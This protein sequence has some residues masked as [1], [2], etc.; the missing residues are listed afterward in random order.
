MKATS[1][2]DTLGSTE[3]HLAGKAALAEAID[4]EQS[5][6]SG[7]RLADLIIPANDMIGTRLLKQLG[8]R[9]GFGIGPRK[10]RRNSDD[11]HG[12][13]VLYA[14]EDTPLPSYV[15]KTNTHGI[16]YNP[17]QNAPEFAA[18]A[19]TTTKQL[20]KGTASKPAGFGVGVFEDEED[21]VY[22]VDDTEKYDRVL[23]E[24]HP[25]VGPK[26]GM[27]KP[28][29]VSNGSVGAGNLSNFVRAELAPTVN[30]RNYPL[31]S[32]PIDYVEKHVF[33]AD[34]L[35]A[36]IPRRGLT[37]DDRGKLLGETPVKAPKRS[38]F[39]LMR[40]EAAAEL[41]AY[42]EKRQAQ[43]TAH[44]SDAPIAPAT[45]P[46]GPLPQVVHVEPKVAMSAL[47]GF[48]PFVSDQAKQARYVAFCERNAGVPTATPIYPAVSHLDTLDFLVGPKPSVEHVL[49]GKTH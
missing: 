49:V 3:R 32:V 12:K 22:G 47:K 29:D 10:R 34:D 42:F 40:P 31:P 21:D 26:R 1:E 44:V 43:R 27:R 15:M 4:Q 33:E 39:D 5:L 25:T 37:T 9:E 30:V 14:P 28:G 46:V 11:P 48:L 41:K 24:D 36:L 38:V 18:A 13:G 16:G 7:D 2:F 45:G 19:A 17:L 23:D 6:L 8:W 35:Q 20:S